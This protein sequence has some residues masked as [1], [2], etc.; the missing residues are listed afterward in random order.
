MLNM[1]W[2]GGELKLQIELSARVTEKIGC[3]CIMLTGMQPSLSP[4]AIV[5]GNLDTG[6]SRF[7]PILRQMFK[8]FQIFKS[9]L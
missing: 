9:F 8:W 6:V 5:T 1:G 2:G 7:F 4:H 3:F